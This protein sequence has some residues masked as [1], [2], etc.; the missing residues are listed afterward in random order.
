MSKKL[1]AYDIK[2]LKLLIRRDLLSFMYTSLQHD[3][4]R[5]A[6]L[7]DGV[8]TGTSMSGAAAMNFMKL[9]AIAAGKTVDEKEIYKA[10]AREYLGSLSQQLSSQGF[11]NRDINHQEA[12]EFHKRF[13]RNLDSVPMPGP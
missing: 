5:Y 10:M 9:T 7:A 3:G 13:S 1:G 12:W 4:Y 11:V 8:V 2:E 6:A